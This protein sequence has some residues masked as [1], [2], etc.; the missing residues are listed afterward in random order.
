MKYKNFFVMNIN[1]TLSFLCR[2]KVNSDGS[3]DETKLESYAKD[4]GHNPM[5]VFDFD[6]AHEWLSSKLC[7]LECADEDVEEIEYI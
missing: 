1:G 6:D 5:W 3:Y 7:E 2:R 4:R